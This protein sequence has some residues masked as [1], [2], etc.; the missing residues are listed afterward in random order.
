[1]QRS[2]VRFPSTPPIFCILL[3]IIHAQKIFFGSLNDT[4]EIQ[5]LSPSPRKTGVDFKSFKKNNRIK[6]LYVIMPR[7]NLNGY[8]NHTISNHFI[9]YCTH[10]FEK[11][12]YKNKFNATGKIC[13][14]SSLSVYY[15]VNIKKIWSLIICLQEVIPGCAS[16]F[17]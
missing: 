9:I 13:I 15:S 2:G 3:I 6:Y 12:E 14:W 7:W 5:F 8:S 1:M 17:G 16:C 11:D 10:R 4:K